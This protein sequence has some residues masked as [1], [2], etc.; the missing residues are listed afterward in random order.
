MKAKDIVNERLA[1]LGLPDDIVEVALEGEPQLSPAALER[2]KRKTLKK[3]ETTPVNNVTPMYHRK[4][5][6]WTSITRTTAWAAVAAV[7]LVAITTFAAPDIV[8]AGVRKLVCTIPGVSCGAKNEPKAMKSVLDSLRQEVPFLYEFKGFG[9]PTLA[10]YHEGMVTL[11]YRVP[12]GDTTNKYGADVQ[13]FIF[14][15]EYEKGSEAK[16]NESRFSPRREIKPDEPS[17]TFEVNGMR[18]SYYDRFKG[19]ATTEDGRKGVSAESGLLDIRPVLRGA[20]DGVYYE[21]ELQGNFTYEELVDVLKNFR[22][23]GQ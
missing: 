6:V 17:E 23:S 7:A 18:W 11:Y 8:Q 1:G 22:P 9:E 12:E 14:V 2:I 4:K 10:G 16:T 21:I 19:T 15:R 3:V 20:N 13:G 5:N